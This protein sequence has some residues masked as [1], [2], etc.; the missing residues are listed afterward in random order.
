[1]K[2]DLTIK[3]KKTWMEKLKIRLVCWLFCNPFWVI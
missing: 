1:M 2:N 3:K